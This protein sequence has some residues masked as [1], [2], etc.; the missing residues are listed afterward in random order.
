MID[1]HETALR[2]IIPELPV[3]AGS[4]VVAAQEHRSA[5]ELV[6]LRKLLVAERP[7]DAAAPVVAPPSPERGGPSR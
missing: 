7:V 2:E 6:A 3:P 4:K 1:L 5:S